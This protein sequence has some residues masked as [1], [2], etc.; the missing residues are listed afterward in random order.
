[1][2]GNEASI[3]R[4]TMPT[5]AGKA[6]TGSGR[7]R[8]WWVTVRSA[9]QGGI[10]IAGSGSREGSAFVQV[11]AE[12][13]LLSPEVEV[14]WFP[15]EGLDECLLRADAHRTAFYST[16][17]SRRPCR[18]SARRWTFPSLPVRLFINAQDRGCIG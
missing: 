9:L 7:A 3:P 2:A 10:R 6:A 8:W 16:C 4:A 17:R 5:S 18:R 11:P 15:A 14:P 12:G 1:M 13:P